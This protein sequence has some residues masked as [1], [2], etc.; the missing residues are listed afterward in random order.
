MIDAQ[1]FAT[2]RWIN[3]IRIRRGYLP[4]SK[5]ALVIK[6]TCKRDR[7]VG[8]AGDR[9]ARV[10]IYFVEARAGGIA[11]AGMKR[12]VKQP[13]FVRSDNSRAN[14]EKWGRR[15]RAVFQES[16][17]AG[18]LDDEQAVRTIAW[19]NQIERSGKTGRDRLQFHAH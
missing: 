14:I 18:L 2:R 5:D 10:S 13:A 6:R 19:R 15:E 17:A 1:N 12:Q 8:R 7:E 9:F 16:N 11:E 4:F 3:H